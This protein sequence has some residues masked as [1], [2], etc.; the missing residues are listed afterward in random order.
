MASFNIFKNALRSHY[1]NVLATSLLLSGALSLAAPVFADGTAVGT[2]ITN[3][4]TATY[5]DPVTDPTGTTAINATSNTVSVTVSEVAGITVV[6]AGAPVDGTTSTAG[7]VQGDVV[8]FDFIVTNTGNDPTQFFIPG[9]PTTVN[10]SAAFSS[11]ANPILVDLTGGTNYTTTVPAAGLTTSGSFPAGSTIRVRVPVTVNSSAATASLISVV[12]G[13]TGANDNSTGTQN[14]PYP[15]APSGN[16]LRTVDNATA[17][18]GE[19]NTTAPANGEREASALSPDATVSAQL[20]AFATVLKNGPTYNNNGTF[21]ILTDDKLTYSLGLNVSNTVAS[22][23]SGY[24]PGDLAGRNVIGIGTTYILISDVIPAGTVF[25]SSVLPSAPANWTAVYSTDDPTT[26]NATT[27]SWTTVQPTAASITRVGFVYNAAPIVSG[28]NGP[29]LRGAS[30]TGFSFVVSPTASF[31][32]GQIANLAQAFGS[33]QSAPG[34]AVFDE[35]GDQDPSNFTGGVADPFNATTNTGIATPLTDGTDPGGNTGSGSDGED[36]IFSISYLLNGPKLA[37]SA[38]G[39]TDA[40][41]DFTNQSTQVPSGTAPGSSIDP[42]SITFNNTLRNPGNTALSNLSLVP[43]DGTATGTVPTNTKVTITYGAQVVT[44]NYNGTDY[45]FF[46]GTPISTTINA[47]TSVNYTVAVDLPAGTSLS[48]DTGTGFAV[49]IVAF[50]DQG[51]AGLDVNDSFNTTID[52]V[53]TGYL[54]LLKESR[55]LVGTGPT[56]QGTDGTFSTGS[57]SPAPGNIIEYRVTYTNI[58][59]DPTGAGI[60]NVILNAANTTIT[61]DGT[62]G[63]GGNNWALDN[64]APAGVIDTSNVASSATDPRVGA[65]ITFFSGAGPNPNGAATTT[66]SGTTQATDVTK[67]VDTVGTVGPAT[68]DATPNGTFTFQRKLN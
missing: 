10:G 48:T 5:T 15:T 67:Y 17:I 50:V 14:Q 42:G 61:E 13:N 46:S 57:K 43:S 8:Y 63:S 45:V 1:K 34:N 55:I 28:G 38:Q 30:L 32:G 62:I 58:A 47:T 18:N 31:S 26:I 40:N 44:Y 49:P 7:I 25:N 27:A 54:K 2:T 3:T 53:Y 36:N 33:T 68:T 21:N 35:S 56:V 65:V 24:A 4:A 23:S 66:T 16:D 22:G 39:P 60:G 11:S 29:V 64:A 12:L 41:D 51:T 52:R 19:T 20:Q 59:N 37:P 9:A 6:S